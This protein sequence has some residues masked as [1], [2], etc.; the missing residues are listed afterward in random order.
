MVLTIVNSLIIAIYHTLC[1]S[2]LLFRLWIV[3]IVGLSGDKA[4]GP[5]G[6][7]ENLGVKFDSH[8]QIGLNKN[9]GG[10]GQQMKK[11]PPSTPA[12]K[13][14]HK[15][16]SF[17]ILDVENAPIPEFAPNEE[18]VGVITMEDVIEE[19]LQVMVIAQHI[20]SDGHV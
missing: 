14:R 7:T 15:G 4:V 11:S 10:Q 17:C 18:V 19:L 16:C 20:A 9:S 5:I 2:N 6:A 8:P 1:Y 12:F 13:K 3:L